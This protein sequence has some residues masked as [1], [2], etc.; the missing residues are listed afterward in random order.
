MREYNGS[1]GINHSRTKYIV[2]HQT[3]ITN[4]NNNNKATYKCTKS[5]HTHDGAHAQKREVEKQVNYSP[6]NV[7]YLP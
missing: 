7:P 5:M 2:T 1:I 6:E 4:N 3:T